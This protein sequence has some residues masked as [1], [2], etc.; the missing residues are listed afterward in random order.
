MKMG[1]ANHAS[2]T[3][4]S[5]SSLLNP[6]GIFGGPS[7]PS[8]N[9]SPSHKNNDDNELRGCGQCPFHILQWFLHLE[10]T[11]ERENGEKACNN[12]TR[13]N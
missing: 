9:F 5:G 1:H 6:C 8:S 7:F 13:E 4:T 3:N 2:A 10:I 11:D 12:I